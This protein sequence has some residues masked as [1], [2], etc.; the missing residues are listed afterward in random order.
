MFPSPRVSS[1]SPRFRRFTSVQSVGID[2]LP[3][4]TTKLEAE[5]FVLKQ[6]VALASE[7]KSVL[8]SWVRYEQ[9]AKEN[10]Q[11]ALAKSVIENVL[12]TIQDEKTQKDIL[13]S[14]VAE[15]ER[16]CHLVI[17]TSLDS[18][19]T[20]ASAPALQSWS[21]RRLSRV[22]T[23]RSTVTCSIHN[24]YL[25]YADGCLCRSFYP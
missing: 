18:P 25:L 1:L 10:E 19:L 4:E 7:L 23:R 15:V 24:R 20:T 22:E 9:Q 14:A 17:G 12:K 16:E 2:V 5:S 3:Q 21:G 13:T 8:D 11:A 6:K